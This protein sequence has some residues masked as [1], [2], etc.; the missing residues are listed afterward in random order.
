[1]ASRAVLPD[2]L[3]TTTAPLGA[4]RWGPTARP[5]GEAV[6]PVCSS[7]DTTLARSVSLQGGN[8]VCVDLFKQHYHLEFI[9]YMYKSGIFLRV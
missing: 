7:Y 5:S 3:V 4:P 6:H 9:T 1:M 2:T 8:C